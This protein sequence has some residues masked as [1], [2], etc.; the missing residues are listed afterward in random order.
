MVEMGE[1]GEMEKMAVTEG[2][3]G[4]TPRPICHMRVSI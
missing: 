4:N 3:E 2:R 1:M